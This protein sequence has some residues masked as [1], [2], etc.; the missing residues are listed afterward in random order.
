MG[1]F[2]LQWDWQN[3]KIQRCTKIHFPNVKVSDL[4]FA[5]TLGFETA[6]YF[7]AHSPTDQ[8]HNVGLIIVDWQYEWMTGSLWGSFLI[9]QDPIINGHLPSLYLLNTKKSYKHA[10]MLFLINVRL[11]WI[12]L[13]RI[14]VDVWKSALLNPLL[15]PAP[16]F[17]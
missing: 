5:Y 14:W 10:Y 7:S 12:R 6:G 3:M 16:F 11:T 4:H 8:P 15:D 13:L 9:K 1:Y 2:S 17:L